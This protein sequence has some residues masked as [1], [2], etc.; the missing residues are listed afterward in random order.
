MQG[1][2]IEH[3]HILNFAVNNTVP[4]AKVQVCPILRIEGLEKILGTYAN[5]TMV[6]RIDV[7]AILALA[8]SSGRDSADCL[9]KVVAHEL[10][11]SVWLKHHGLHEFFEL[12]VTTGQYNVWDVGVYKGPECIMRSSMDDELIFCPYTT[13]S[14]EGVNA[15]D[16]VDWDPTQY[17]MSD[18]NCDPGKGDCLHTIKVNPVWS[19]RD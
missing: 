10:G 16:E 19:W 14:P 18:W 7:D 5:Y 6:A 9:M 13:P 17:G 3:G 1:A 15:E 11:H 2:G 4:S 8:P 12:D